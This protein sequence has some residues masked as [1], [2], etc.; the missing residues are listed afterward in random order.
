MK[1][2]KMKYG[3]VLLFLA[4]CSQEFVADGGVVDAATD[5]KY[6][7]AMAQLGELWDTQGEDA[8][9]AFLRRE[10]EAGNH[11]AQLRL[12]QWYSQG[13][14]QDAKEMRRWLK[15]AAARG[16]AQAQFQLAWLEDG[17]AGEQW[18]RRAA[19]QGY[20]PAQARLAQMQ[21]QRGQASAGQDWVSQ[22]AAQDDADAQ[23]ALGRRLWEQGDEAQALH[24][25]ELSAAQGHV[26][27]QFELGMVHHLRGDTAR[28]TAWWQQAAAGGH[29]QAKR[30]LRR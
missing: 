16:D 22:A 12:A 5:G 7:A 21:E 28:A 13:K 11:Y 1:Y 17:E 20:A 15:A 29:A 18:L 10:A 30:M 8:A 4:A 3:V 2:I 6:R 14:Q 9:L 19:D 27:A 23:Y 24:W 25:L 26:T